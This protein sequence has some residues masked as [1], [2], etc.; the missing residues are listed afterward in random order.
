VWTDF[1][2]VNG[3]QPYSSFNTQKVELLTQ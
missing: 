3:K 2:Q 1:Q